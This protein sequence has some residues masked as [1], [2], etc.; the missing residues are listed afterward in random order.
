[1]YVELTSLLP[2]KEII[3]INELANKN[4]LKIRNYFI[5]KNDIPID[6]E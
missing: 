2:N 6:C 3:I 1:M 4:D 5:L